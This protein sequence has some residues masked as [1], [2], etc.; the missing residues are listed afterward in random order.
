MAVC[1]SVRLCAYVCPLFFSTDD[2]NGIFKSG[3]RSSMQICM[4]G[5]TLS[6]NEARRS[7]CCVDK[8]VDGLC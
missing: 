3:S 4:Y 5:K 6:K 2:R 8:C 7:I 1:V